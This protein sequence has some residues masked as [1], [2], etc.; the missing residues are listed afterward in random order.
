MCALSGAATGCASPPAARP[1]PGGLAEADAQLL[2]GC[3]DCLVDARARYRQLAVGRERPH[4]LV[5]ILEADLLLALRD[6]ELGLPTVD[7]ITDARRVAAELPRDL[8]AERYLALAEAVPTE[9]LALPIRSSGAF[10]AAHLPLLTRLPDELA[11]LSRGKLRPPAREYLRLALECAYPMFVDKTPSPSGPSD[12]PLLAFRKLICDSGSIAALQ[13][14]RAREPRFVETSFF[15]ATTEIVLLPTQGPGQARAHLGEAL[16]KFPASPAIT[17][18]TAMYDLAIGD[19]AEGLVFY[20]RTLA[21]V[22]AHEPAMLGRTMCL[23]H[24]GRH[25]EAIDAATRAIALNATTSDGYYWRAQNHHTLGHLAE[26]HTDIAAAKDRSVAPSILSLAGVIEHDVGEL[27]PAEAD[28]QTAVAADDQDC[29]ARWYLG[30]VH[31]QRKR[32]LPAAHAFEDAMACYRDR[33]EASHERV[34]A[35]QARADID[36]GYR[37]RVIAGLEASIEADI[38]QQHLAALTAANHDVTGGDLAAAR[39]LVDIAAEDPALADRVAKLRVRLDAAP[40]AR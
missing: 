21:L 39:K 15:I 13:A 12:P 10:R 25:P 8:E 23:T 35:L 11:W 17:L 18:L 5:R 19:D 6:K 28:L 22:P 30:L 20:D 14:V 27:D 7:A 33:A 36:A 29:T 37:A 24:L 16:A 31:R 2:Q 9:A 26:A 34:Q 32:W 40:R 4:V 38:R 1:Q 3:Y